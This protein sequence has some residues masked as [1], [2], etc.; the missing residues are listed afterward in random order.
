MKMFV[1]R[2]IPDL[3]DALQRHL[4]KATP[5]SGKRA[6]HI[7]F[8]GDWG[9]RWRV[10]QPI[11]LDELLERLRRDGFSGEQVRHHVQWLVVDDPRVVQ[12]GKVIRRYSGPDE[13]A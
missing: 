1:G 12:G 5:V 4:P 2:P 8:P 10:E 6:Y 7:A 11:E 13:A 9:R 3:L